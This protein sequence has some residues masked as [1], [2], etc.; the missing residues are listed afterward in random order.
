MKRPQ[1]SLQTARRLITTHLGAKSTLSKEV[2]EQERKILRDA[3]G[4]SWNFV[5]MYLKNL[6]TE[7][8]RQE[9]QSERDAW[10]GNP[11]PSTA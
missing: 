10:D 3:R 4:K 11:R 9:R 8:K 1:T 7:Q 6:F 2:L 5:V